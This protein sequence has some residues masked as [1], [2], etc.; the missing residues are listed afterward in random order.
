M[1]LLP[2]LAWHNLLHNK[3]RTLVAVAG[4]CFAI[5]LLFMQLGFLASVLR[6]AMLIYD[7]L[8][9]DLLIS[10]P[11]YV[12]LTSP[13]G[14]PRARL[15]QAEAL[16]E[17]QAAM[18]VY[19]SRILWRNTDNNYRRGVVV[20][21]VRPKDPVSKDA[22]LARQLPKLTW[23]ESVLTDRMSRPECGPGD[24][25]HV[26]EIGTQRVKVVGQFAVSPGF[27][28]GLVFVSDETFSRL[29]GGWLQ[30]EVNIGL[31]KLRPGTDPEQARA[32]LRSLL[33]EDVQVLT[34]P[35]VAWREGYYWVV[36]TATGVIFGTGVLVAILF[37]LVITYQ[38]LSMEVSQRLSE[39][40]TLKAVGFSDPS[41]GG[42]VLRQGI[43]LGA[44]SYLPG[45]AFACAI[46]QASQSVT[47][48]PISMTLGRAV[49][50]FILDLVVCAVSGL[51]A[52][53]ILR[54]AD[55]VDLF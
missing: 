2:P 14:F 28:A 3:L 32:R 4:I 45:F 52:L 16:P 44:V 25:G 13:G 8:D 41:L 20:I 33:P 43:I 12:I 51:L 1:R 50:V 17:V 11:H 35:E 38:V 53:R 7:C 9:Y 21:G 19:V 48:L 5:T 22:E 27:E 34:R 49:A 42:V 40:A 29:L 37:G 39:Y 36:S 15:S 23:P 30:A 26:T 46:Y 24:V 47:G 31:V 6:V 10:S 18:P 54:R 55:P